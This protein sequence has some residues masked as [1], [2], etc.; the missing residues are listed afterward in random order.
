MENFIEWIFSTK[1]GKFIFVIVFSGITN[2]IITL[3]FPLHFAP[4]MIGSVAV[5]IILSVS[6]WRLKWF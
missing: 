5:A 2:G 6:D 3:I 4:M 1:V